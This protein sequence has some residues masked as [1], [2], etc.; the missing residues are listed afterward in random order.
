MYFDKLLLT[1]YKRQSNEISRKGRDTLLF[2]AYKSKGCVWAWIF[3][4]SVVL[5][6]GA[7]GIIAKSY[8][9]FYCNF[10]REKTEFESCTHILVCREG[11]HFEE[12][13]VMDISGGDFRI[14]EYRKEK[15]IYNQITQKFSFQPAKLNDQDLLPWRLSQ[16]ITKGGLSMFEARQKLSINGPNTITIDNVPVLVMLL[17]KIT[18]IFYLFQIASVIIWLVEGYST[19]AWLILFMS[20]ASIIW[21]IYNAKMNEKQLRSLTE[22]DAEFFVLR[23]NQVFKVPAIEL[24]AGD[25][26]VLHP[27]TLEPNTKLPCDVVVMQGECLMDESS[28][29]GET[30]PVLK[31]PLQIPDISFQEPLDIER[32]RT[33]VLFGGSTILQLR[34]ENRNFKPPSREASQ[35]F[36]D[37]DIKK[38]RP[39][40]SARFNLETRPSHHGSIMAIVLSTGFSTSKGDLFKSI[41][42][43]TEV[44]LKLNRDALSFLMIL[45]FVAFLAF[46]NKMV[47][48]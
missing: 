36:L 40:K 42:F 7:F 39:I 44:E 45:G 21:E 27:D 11:K 37:V 15:F 14:I 43:P 22:L 5:S 41:L 1:F 25:I 34:P 13:Q 12:V 38:S 24:V 20:S 33:N 31:L 6:L 47:N 8:P 4:A 10:F 46:I 48:G 29:T 32:N 9:K 19:Y 17:D 35:E 26:V 18:Q 3:R 2:E 30:V 23:E 28:L 16:L